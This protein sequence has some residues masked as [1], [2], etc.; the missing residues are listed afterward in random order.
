MS[1]PSER[2]GW[3]VTAG[4]LLIA[5]SGIAV[6][7]FSRGQGVQST[8]ETP[9]PV[10]ATSPSREP[11]GAHI[12][13]SDAIPKETHQALSPEEVQRLAKQRQYDFD[14]IAAVEGML[15]ASSVQER[16]ELYCRFTIAQVQAL[17]APNGSGDK[18]LQGYTRKANVNQ[19]KA[20]VLTGYEG[21]PGPDELRDKAAKAGRDI[22]EIDLKIP[23]FAAASPTE[24]VADPAAAPAS[25][26]ARPTA[27]ANAAVAANAESAELRDQYTALATRA[28]AARSGLKAFEQQQSRQGIMLRADI[29]EAQSRLDDQLEAARSSLMIGDLEGVRRNLLYAQSAAETIEK[30][31]GR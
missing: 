23:S 21:M 17:L 13:E 22:A 7:M 10:D 5:V 30:F 27:P 20:M 6:S 8:R 19:C 25:S 9:R 15:N 11:K 28:N 14:L 12:Q 16:V 2:L 29:R 18:Q 26:V 24:V 3:L 31:L 4:V 1:A